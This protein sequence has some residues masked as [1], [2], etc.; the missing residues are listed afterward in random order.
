MMFLDA[1]FIIEFIC[2]DNIITSGRRSWL[3]MKKHDRDLVRHDL[4]L[5]D[6]QLPFQVID[7]LARA[8][9]CDEFTLHLLT[10]RFLQMP[11]LNISSAPTPTYLD[12]IKGVSYLQHQQGEAQAPVHLLQYYRDLWINVLFGDDAEEEDNNDN[13]EEEDHLAVFPPFTDTELKKAEEDLKELRARGVI[14][15]NIVAGDDQLIRFLRNIAQPTESNPQAIWNVKRQISIYFRSKRFSLVVACAEMKQRYF[16]GPWSF[17]VF[18]AVI[19][20]VGMTVIQTVLT[21]I[22]TYK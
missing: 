16:S 14:Q 3:N 11:F 4:L 21:G 20:T 22:Q 5:Y 19:F 12:Y 1:C 17:L 18:L 9:R 2:N 7:A 8:F 6:N 13:K 15:I 10:R